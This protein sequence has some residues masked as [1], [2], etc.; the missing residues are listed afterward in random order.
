MGSGTSSFSL[1]QVEDLS[2]KVAIVTG[3]NA[4]IGFGIAKAL[5]FKG[6]TVIIASRNLKRVN[7][8]VFKLQGLCPTGKL[9]GMVMDLTAFSSIDKFVVEFTA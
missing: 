4:G 8:S 9:S 2:G 3:G 6:A 7:E 1:N 5:A